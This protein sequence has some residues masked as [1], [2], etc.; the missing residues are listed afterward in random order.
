MGIGNLAAEKYQE[1]EVS[2]KKLENVLC[3]DGINK[4]KAGY[5]QAIEVCYFAR[6]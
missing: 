4:L 2:G 6:V 3:K 1:Q 5:K